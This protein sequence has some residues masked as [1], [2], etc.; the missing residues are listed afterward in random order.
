MG[1]KR[2]LAIKGDDV[3][4]RDGFF[5]GRVA[6]V[7]DVDKVGLWALVRATD[8]GPKYRIWFHQKEVGVL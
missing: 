5:G 8:V 4:I 1:Y 6:E 2:R 3:V 7:D